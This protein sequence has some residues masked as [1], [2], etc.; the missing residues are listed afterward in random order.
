MAVVVV[1]V[2]A[3]ADDL[4][5]LLADS[6]RPVR[7]GKPGKTGEM[8]SPSPLLLY[9]DFVDVASSVLTFLLLFGVFLMLLCCCLVCFY[10]C[11][12]VVWYV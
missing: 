12:G 11:F 1:A 7:G 8:R 10:C 4:A 3:S 9:L 2:D 6:Q 5:R